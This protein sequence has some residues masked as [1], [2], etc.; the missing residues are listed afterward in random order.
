VLGNVLATPVDST[1]DLGLIPIVL[2]LP[3]NSIGQLKVS[4]ALPGPAQVAVSIPVNTSRHLVVSGLDVDLTLTGTLALEGALVSEPSSLGLVAPAL[5]L[6]C[7]LGRRSP[8]R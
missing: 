1:F 6:A 3:S 4:G 8:R 7:G 5:A 2:L